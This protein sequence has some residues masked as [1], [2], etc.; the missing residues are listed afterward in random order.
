MDIRSRQKFGAVFYLLCCLLFILSVFLRPPNFVFFHLPDSFPD[1]RF[2]PFLLAKN[3]YCYL[4]KLDSSNFLHCYFNLNLPL[5]PGVRP[6]SSLCPA[7]LPDRARDSREQGWLRDAPDSLPCSFLHSP[8]HLI[9]SLGQHSLVL[10]YL[11]FLEGEGGGGYST[12][13]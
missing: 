5:C 2:S 4:S 11:R 13:P 7:T 9:F 1:N 3:N 12:A 6:S 8:K 10:K